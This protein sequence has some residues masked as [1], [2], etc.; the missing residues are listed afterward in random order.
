[1]N[2]LLNLKIRKYE[3]AIH[4][5]KQANKHFDHELLVLVQQCEG[6]YKS[7]LKAPNDSPE[8]RAIIKL[9]D[10]MTNLGNFVCWHIPHFA[11]SE[12]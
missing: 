11:G 2:K 9:N 8:W 6:R 7:V 10:F 1:M 3:K 4:D 5:H 12:T